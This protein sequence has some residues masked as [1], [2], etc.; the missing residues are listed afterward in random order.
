MSGS[1]L[2]MYFI[3]LNG[4]NGKTQETY[5]DA[6]D[7]PIAVEAAC[8]YCRM[9]KKPQSIKSG[10]DIIAMLN[11][12][13]AREQVQGTAQSAIDY[14]SNAASGFYPNTQILDESEKWFLKHGDFALE[15]KGVYALQHF[16]N[17]CKCGCKHPIIKIEGVNKPVQKEPFINISQK[18]ASQPIK[19]AVY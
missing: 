8:H 7:I 9:N 11:I 15:D 1:S 12:L 16:I 10:D 3:N 5:V 14:H 4:S 2:Q 13:H 19:I 18:T 17:Y 6:D